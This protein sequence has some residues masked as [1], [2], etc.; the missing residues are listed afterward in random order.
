M[1]GELSKL[2]RKKNSFNGFICN[3]WVA[4]HR[5][6][7]YCILLSLCKFQ[8]YS[9]LSRMSEIIELSVIT[10]DYHGHYREN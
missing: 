3:Q 5:K 1:H 8:N 4:K 2:I 6:Y 9:D 10:E 7:F